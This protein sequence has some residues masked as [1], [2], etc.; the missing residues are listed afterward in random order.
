V[1]KLKPNVNLLLQLA[2]KKKHEK[3]Q[4]KKNNGLL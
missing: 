1:A 4:T 3:G 2:I